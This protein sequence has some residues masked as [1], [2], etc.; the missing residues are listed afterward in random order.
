MKD[1]LSSST[2]RRRAL[3][4]AGGLVFALP[5][6]AAEEGAAAAEKFLGLPVEIWKTAN[7][8]LFL[9]FLVYFLGKP[10]NQ[11]FRKR[12]EDL[13]QLLDKARTDREQ[14]LVLAAQMR[15][16]L[17]KLEVEI[18]EIRQRGATEGEAEKAAQIAAAEKEAESLRRSAAEEIE[19]RLASAKQE[20]ARVAS[21]LAAARA[22]EIL[23]QTMTDEDRK[24]LL[25]DSVQK[26]SRIQ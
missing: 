25:D 15:E 18:S 23:S 10:F 8:L 12:R 17:S 9:G 11:F 3:A 24:R 26:I 22:K 21:S 19:R 13:D 4:A 1:L 20:L 5:L 2:F 7:L 16:R 14:A 6:R